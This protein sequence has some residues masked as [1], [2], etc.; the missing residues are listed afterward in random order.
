MYVDQPRLRRSCDPI[1]LL[2]LPKSDANSIATQAHEF[3]QRR[4]ESGDM[5]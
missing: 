5:R 3:Q 2:L 4:N 1:R